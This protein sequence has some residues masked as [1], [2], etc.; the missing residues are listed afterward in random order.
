MNAYTPHDP[1]TILGT[2]ALLAMV[3][4]SGRA[5]ATF[6]LTRAAR[7]AA[8]ALVVVAVVGVERLDVRE[9]AGVR[10]LAIIG[11]LLYAMKA[12]VTVEVRQ[13]GSPP[14]PLGRWLCFAALWPGMRPGP[15]S[16]PRAAP[17]PGA[18]HLVGK[19]SVR[20][21]IGI[22][23]VAVACLTWNATRSRLLATTLL[24]PGLTGYPITPS[25]P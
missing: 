14:L 21:L 2:V 22:V 20:M 4:V 18:G 3:L 1:A 19:G 25:S 10:M 23:L 7:P 16:R 5:I 9:P 13:Q 11:A 15:F 17:L 8:W 24:L 12:V 6:G